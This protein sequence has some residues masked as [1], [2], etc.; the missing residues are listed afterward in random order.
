M[1]RKESSFVAKVPLI[2]LIG[3]ANLQSKIPA[4]VPQGHQIRVRSDERDQGHWAK[5]LN[6]V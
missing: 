3:A 2:K 5:N 6:V 4:L 1:S